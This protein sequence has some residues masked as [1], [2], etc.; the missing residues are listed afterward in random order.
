MIDPNSIKPILEHFGKEGLS[1][2]STVQ[3]AISRL[4]ALN[5]FKPLLQ[6]IDQS[7]PPETPRRHLFEG[8][9]QVIAVSSSSASLDPTMGASS[10]MK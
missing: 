6:A 8:F 4:K 1:V 9:N 10:N 7:A 2:T 3:L 5:N